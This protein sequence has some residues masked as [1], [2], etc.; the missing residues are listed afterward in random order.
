MVL[1]DSDML[2][3][4][5]MMAPRL[6]ELR[7]VMKP[8]ASIYLHCDTTASHYLKILMDA[9][10]DP[11]NFRNEIIWRRTGSNNSAKRFGPI[12]Q[13]ILF[14]AK[15]SGAPFYRPKGYYTKD[16]V[17]SYFIYED[18][19]G[20]YRAVILTGPG[21]R[22]GVS[23]NPWRGYNPTD[24]GRHWQPASYVYEKYH[25]LTGEDLAKYPLIERL[26]KLDEVGLIHQVSPDSVPQY[27]Y[28]L[29]DAP[30]VPYQD[31]WAY[32]PGTK[33]CVA[34]DDDLGIDQDVKW[35][36]TQDK[37][38]LGYPTQKP[39]GVLRRILAGSSQPGDV[40][41]DPFCGCG[42]TVAAAQAMGRAWIGIDITHL[43][44]NLIKHRLRDSYGPEI[45]D[46]YQVIGEP[47]TVG[48]AEELAA[49]DPYQF[50]WWALGLVGARPVEQKKGAD[51]GIDGRLYFHD[52][53]EGGR[54]K[55]IILS[56]K[57]GLTGV[58]HVRDLRGVIEREK[59][60]IGVLL[61]M[62]EPTAA[63]RKE[64]ASA[65][66]YESAWGKHPRL[67]VLTIQDLLDGKRI[68]Y[69]PSRQVD[70]TFRKAP[71]VP[72]AGGTQL[73][74]RQDSN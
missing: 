12:H 36:T 23:G 42:T 48:G 16:Y 21:I 64:A 63:M 66:F 4:L 25:S 51:K 17:K 52:A 2:A 53:P 13:S 20:R 38:R 24:V 39:E 74:F 72:R 71:R 69:P 1:G 18:E 54:T 19:R 26:D 32:Q 70:R 33:G 15:S 5:S 10:F 6:M 14:Y 60:E 27:K 30:G 62:Q 67:Q 29:D 49:S 35:L 9:I 11:T 46:Q 68:A 59:A 3:Y 50:Q 7:R 47:T 57:A 43:A 31:I 73:E 55:Q 22:E 61:T 8:T 45:E 37:E 65:G 58:A 41:L 34:G 44:I 40:V 56:V 28:Y